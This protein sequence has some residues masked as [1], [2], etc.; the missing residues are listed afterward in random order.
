LRRGATLALGVFA[1]ALLAVPASGAQTSTPAKP[2]VSVSPSVLL[3]YDTICVNYGL[4]S[5]SQYT[6]DVTGAHFKA[7]KVHISL[8]KQPTTVVA[9]ATVK[10]GA[11]SASFTDPSQPAAHESL[12]AKGASRASTRYTTA[13]IT[14]YDY[15]PGATTTVNWDG[16]GWATSSTVRFY[17]GGKVA[18]QETT[19]AAGSFSTSFDYAC[20]RVAT[21]K[22]KVVGTAS[23]KE[24]VVKATFSCPSKA[25]PSVSAAGGSD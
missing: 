24:R 14:C 23:G 12:V 1:A 4:E 6:A 22:A 15:I 2:S 11:F 25:G 5:A 9:T 8:S 16:N 19:S 18:D 3:P 17:I 20:K 13:E 7:G 10:D 21:L